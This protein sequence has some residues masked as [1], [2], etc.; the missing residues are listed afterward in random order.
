ML[1]RILLGII[2]IVIVAVFF[3][4]SMF[5]NYS[6]QE[7]TL[8]TA[9]ETKQEDNSSE[10][11]NMWK[12]ISQVAQVTQGQKDALKE[13]I[14]GYADARKGKDS[15]QAIMNWVQESCP[16]IDTKTFQNLQNIITSSRDSF[17]MRQ[18]E[19]LDLNRQH[20]QLLRQFPSGLFLSLL[21]R[22]E[23][24]VTIVTST[25]TDNSFKTGKD[26]DVKVFNK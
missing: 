23:I 11:D 12:K 1:V 20:K 9:I 10:Y 6:N 22:H 26:D 7:V 4:G 14:V 18:K 13:I 19:L 21:G 15:G 17:T 8:R 16:T 5:V 3:I 24:E 25:R 2:T